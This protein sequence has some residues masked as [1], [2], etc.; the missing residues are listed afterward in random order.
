MILS[1]SHKNL[2]VAQLE[3]EFLTT[4]QPLVN[5]VPISLID[6]SS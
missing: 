1:S 6:P 2:N 3:L 5:K 4:L